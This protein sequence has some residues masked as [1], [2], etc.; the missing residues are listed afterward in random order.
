VLVG[1]LTTNKAGKGEL[2][3]DNSKGCPFPAN[4]PTITA[5]SVINIGTATSGSFAAQVGTRH[6]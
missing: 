1:K 2:K 4:F 5:N 6:R 3:F